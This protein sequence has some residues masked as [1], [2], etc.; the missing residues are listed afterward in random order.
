MAPVGAAWATPPVH[1]V[2]LVQPHHLSFAPG[3]GTRGN[4]DGDLGPEAR[5]GRAAT[6]SAPLHALD[7]RLVVLALGRSL[8][9]RE[10]R[11]SYRQLALV[12]GPAHDR[13]GHA[14]TRRRAT[15]R[16]S[17]SLGPARGCISEKAS[18]SH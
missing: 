17:S 14:S 13:S 11:L 9:G 5:R 16:S 4:A 8:L 10:V 15:A 18:T 2:Y 1:A 12:E 3:A 6:A 7:E